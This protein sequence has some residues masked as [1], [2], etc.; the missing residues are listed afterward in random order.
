MEFTLP[1]LAVYTLLVFLAG[2]AVPLLLLRGVLQDR[3]DS[4]FLSFVLV[5]IF[6]IAIVA[7]AALVVMG[8]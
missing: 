8:A 3:E 4:C 7:V 6:V 1:Q 5:A 2:V